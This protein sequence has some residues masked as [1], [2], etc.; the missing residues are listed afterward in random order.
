MQEVVAKYQEE[1]FSRIYI[2]CAGTNTQKLINLLESMF[3]D[4][5]E[6]DL[7]GLESDSGSSC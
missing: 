5:E 3:G 4:P 7:E 1:G 6:P 2:A